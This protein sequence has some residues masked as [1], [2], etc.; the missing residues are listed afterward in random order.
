MLP[1]LKFSITAVDKATASVRKVNDSISKTLRPITRLQRSMGQLG[2]EV[3]INK[4]GASLKDVG[5]RATVAADKIGRVV[6]PMTALVGG[7]TIAGIAAL[8]DEWGRLGQQ[9]ARTAQNIGIATYDLQS[10]RGATVAAG[11]PAQTLDRTLKTLGD[12]LEDATYGRNMP[13]LLMMNRLGISMHRTAD[14][15]VDTKRALLDLSR[16]L[17]DPRLKGNAQAQSLVARMFGAEELLPLLRKG[18]AA[19]AAYQKKAEAFGAVMGGPALASANRF[20][21]SLNDLQLATQG[22]RNRIGEKL[23]PVMQPLV[24]KFTQWIV[25]KAPAYVQEFADA[26]GRIDFDKVLSGI[27]DFLGDIN[28]VVRALGGWKTVLITVIALQG[29]AFVGSIAS[30]ALSIGKLV[31]VI[32]TKALPQLILLKGALGGI[33]LAAVGL[34]GT[35][36]LLVKRL[37][38]IGLAGAA[39]YGIGTVLNPY[40]NKAVQFAT[41]NKDTTLGSSIYDWTHPTASIGLRQHNPG[42]LRSWGKAPVM[43]GFAAFNSDQAGLLAMGLNLRRY[44]SRGIDTISGIVNRWAPAS[45]GNNVGAYIAD[46]SRQT[47]FGANQHLNLNDAKV[48]APLMAGIIRHEQGSNP[49]D[50]ATLAAAAQKVA[51]DVRFHNAPAD[52]TATTQTP[53]GVQVSR[54]HRAMAGAS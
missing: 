31:T 9:V 20:A 45:D 37:G 13:A 12:T 36:G 17:S 16:A 14:G 49:F 21:A 15:S 50:A 18:P 10:L 23:M 33:D 41:G 53:T 19:I 4:I 24:E 47:G 32:A 39:G 1:D 28:A 34:S 30:A 48:L 3:G 5:A 25:L 40:I 6:A 35:L 26:L 29:V 11:L 2:R 43:D 7:G 46:L 22:L 27:G 38:L 44:G 8:A 52:M 54:V 42:N 51:V